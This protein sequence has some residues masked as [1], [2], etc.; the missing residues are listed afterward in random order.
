M[1]DVWVPYRLCT[2]ME[3]KT[4]AQVCLTHSLHSILLV[5]ANYSFSVSTDLQLPL[6]SLSE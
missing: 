5:L 1:S 6:C 3:Q 4:G 2:D